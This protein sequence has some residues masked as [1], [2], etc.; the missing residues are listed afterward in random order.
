MKKQD[1]TKDLAN[2]QIVITRQFAAEVNRVWRAWTDSRELDKWWGPR[3]WPATTK[4]FDFSEGG[5]WHYCMTGPDGTKAWSWIE[6]LTIAT[7]EA[8]TARDSFCDENGVKNPDMPSTHWQVAFKPAG[9]TTQVITTLTFS[10]QAAMQK[11][12]EMGFE[13]GFTEQLDK[14]DEYLMA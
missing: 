9:K 12:I 6:Y 3:T 1:V 14:L 7:L 13:A 4:A 2:K 11:I 10:D 5:H 8:F